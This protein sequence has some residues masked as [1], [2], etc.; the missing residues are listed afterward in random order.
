[1]RQK[2]LISKVNTITQSRRHFAWCLA[3]AESLQLLGYFWWCKPVTDSYDASQ[4]LTAFTV[5]KTSVLQQ[6]PATCLFLSSLLQ[7]LR[8]ERFFPATSKLPSH[9]RCQ[10][11]TGNK[12]TWPRVSHTHTT[13]RSHTRV[14][15]LLLSPSGEHK[16][17]IAAHKKVIFILWQ[18]PLVRSYFRWMLSSVVIH[19]IFQFIQEWH[20]R[21]ETTFTKKCLS[22]GKLARIFLMCL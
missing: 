2:A 8:C 19:N 20:K 13:S 18:T 1:M 5:L 17:D 10:E 15:S 4:W 9:K 14:W 16:L 6:L 21:Q 11:R 3:D 22:Q 7:S 12:S